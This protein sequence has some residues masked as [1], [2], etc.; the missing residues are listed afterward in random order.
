MVQRVECS[1]ELFVLLGTNGTN[2][3]YLLVLRR[4]IMRS[5]S[6]LLIFIF[7]SE[8]KNGPDDAVRLCKIR[9]D[10]I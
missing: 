9:R 3:M 5:D 6:D 4:I 8:K 1:W 10:K 7:R 2:G